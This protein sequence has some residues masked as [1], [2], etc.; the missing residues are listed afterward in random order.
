MGVWRCGGVEVWG[1]GGVEG[2]EVWRRL[3]HEWMAD[4]IKLQ[5]FKASIA[6]HGAS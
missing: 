1:V 6:F 3:K 2:L 4:E 5:R